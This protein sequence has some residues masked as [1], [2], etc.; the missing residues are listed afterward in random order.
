MYVFDYNIYKIILSFD[1]SF[2]ELTCDSFSLD[3]RREI[4]GG[5]Y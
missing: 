2:V 5:E 4:R 1:F 3:G